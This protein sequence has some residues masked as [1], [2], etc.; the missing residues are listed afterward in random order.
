MVLKLKI[1]STVTSIIFQILDQVSEVV[2]LMENPA[3]GP[4][5][6][7]RLQKFIMIHSQILHPNNALMVDVKHTLLHLLGNSEG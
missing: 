5:T 2:T 3:S 7:E 6:P 4:N 1:Q